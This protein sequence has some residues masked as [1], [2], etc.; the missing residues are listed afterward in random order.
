MGDLDA[1]YVDLDYG[2]GLLYEIDY[3][4]IEE[5]NVEKL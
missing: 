5:V 1:G 2:D 3:D 4:N